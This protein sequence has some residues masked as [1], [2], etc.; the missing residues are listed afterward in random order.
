MVGLDGFAIGLRVEDRGWRM[1]EWLAW[2]GA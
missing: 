1:E 2:V